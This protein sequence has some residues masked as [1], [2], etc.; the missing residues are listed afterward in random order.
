MSRPRIPIG[1]WGPIH[2]VERSPGKWR[3][4][5]NFRDTDDVTRVVEA[6]ESS[7]PRAEIRL[8]AKLGERARHQLS[9]TTRVT[10][11]PQL[12]VDIVGVAG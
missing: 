9:V 5:A 12:S 1:S 7:L 8:I 2:H 3:A 11:V 10:C 4:W 6:Y